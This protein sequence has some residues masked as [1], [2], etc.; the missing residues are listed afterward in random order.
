MNEIERVARAIWEQRCQHWGRYRS[1]VPDLCGWDDLT[2]SKQRELLKEAAAA[3]AAMR[4]EPVGWQPIETAPKD[5]AI[6]DVWRKEFGRETVYWGRRPH[7]C[8]EMGPHCDSDWHREKQPGWVCS[9]FGEYVG[10]DHA[11][12]THWMPLP[13]P[14]ASGKD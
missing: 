4:G 2:Q 3:I 13:T 14:P 5:G 8:G 6:I 7:E 11:P 10:G 1:M 12:F 9:T